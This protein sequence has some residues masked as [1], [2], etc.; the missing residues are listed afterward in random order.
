MTNSAAL[1]VD[2]RRGVRLSVQTKGKYGDYDAYECPFRRHGHWQ[3]KVKSQSRSESK[4]FLKLKGDFDGQT[5][6]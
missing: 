5:I 3:S 2:A 6:R 1:S 4:Q